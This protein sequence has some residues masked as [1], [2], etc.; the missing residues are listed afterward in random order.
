ME[1]ILVSDQYAPDS[2]SERAEFG[3][4][5]VPVV[6]TALQH[7]NLRQVA[8]RTGSGHGVSFSELPVTGLLVLRARSERAALQSALQTTVN[9]KL[10][11]T[12]QS[13]VSVSSGSHKS[14][15][16]IRWVA[17]DEWMLS[18]P[19]QDAFDIETRLRSSL[20]GNSVA[21]VNVTGGYSV[22]QLSGQHANDVLKKSTV[23]D[24]HP[25]NFSVGKV[26]N[27]TFA[28]AQVMLRCVSNDEYEL[29]V[30]RSFAD[31]VWH[32]IQVASK[33]Y[34]LSVSRS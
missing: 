5:N 23:Y 8:T 29:I 4:I 18:C 27:T 6:E 19:A 1:K 22:L 9:I 12:L 15:Y 26:V 16:C 10:P 7:V 17:P 28:K 20:G 25:Q 21:I 3:D 11:D 30:R 2:L 33:E 24:V 32:W 34:G 13:E 14:V 31:Y